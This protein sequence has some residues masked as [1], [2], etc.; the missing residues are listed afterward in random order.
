MEKESEGFV[1]R[2]AE[3]AA[4]DEALGRAARLNAPQTV[5][6][7][8]ADGLGKSRLLDEWQTKLQQA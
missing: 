1:G 5:T 2:R 8:A 4:L 3:V 6:V 7:I